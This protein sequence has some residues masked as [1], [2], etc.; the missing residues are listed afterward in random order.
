[1]NDVH[2]W[3]PAVH[4]F[5]K[6]HCLCSLGRVWRKKELICPEK[7]YT[8]ILFGGLALSLIISGFFEGQGIKT[9]GVIRTL[10]CLFNGFGSAVFLLMLYRLPKRLA[11][12]RL[13]S[14]TSKRKHNVKG[15]W[16]PL[17]N[18]QGTPSEQEDGGNSPTRLWLSLAK[19]LCYCPISST[20]ASG[21]FCWLG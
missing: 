7:D 6:A 21:I 8:L 12:I 19:F 18:V 16:F 9:T 20:S 4:R 17:P 5:A 3:M 14:S 11:F 10:A 15:R 1:M 13:S 2:W